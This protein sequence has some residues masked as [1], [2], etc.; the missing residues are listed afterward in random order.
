MIPA[1]PVLDMC[2]KEVKVYVHIETHSSI[3]H[4]SQKNWKQPKCPSV[5]KWMKCSMEYYVVIKRN[6]PLLQATILMNLKINML[7]EG[8][9]SE[10]KK[11]KRREYILYDSIRSKL[12]KMQTITVSADQQVVW[13]T[14]RE[15]DELYGET[16]KLLGVVE[17]FV[18]MVSIACICV[19]TGQMVCF[20]YMWFIVLQLHFDKII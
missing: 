17:M 5:G 19:K 12:Q 14:G 4:N 15:R 18:V 6:K 8:S 16:R 3:I 9:Q 10:K 2:P 20:K 7:N 1:I 13:K 11:K